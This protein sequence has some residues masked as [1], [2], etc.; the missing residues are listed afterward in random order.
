LSLK[1]KS[2]YAEKDESDGTRVLV[3]R[4]YPRGV[5]K[6]RFDQWYRHA[7]PEVALLREYKNGG[8]DWRE[9]SK[10]FKA[11][12]RTSPES[13]KAVEDLV[14]L[15]GKEENVTLLCYEK[16]GEKCHRN[17]LKTIVESAARKQKSAKKK[18]ES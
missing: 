10:K 17:I 1:T 16:E 5:K 8:I 14:Q 15:L 11:Q 12:M 9:F 3:T 13:K 7:S 4:Y 18:L 6:D 2:I